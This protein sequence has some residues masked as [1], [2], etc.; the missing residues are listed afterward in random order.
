MK[1]SQIFASQVNKKGAYT[2]I[3]SK[4]LPSTTY[5]NG[6]FLVISTMSIVQAKRIFF[7]IILDISLAK[8][9]LK[10]MKL[11]SIFITG[12]HTVAINGNI[13]GLYF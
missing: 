12:S 6:F 13:N 1:F 8:L 2:K 4:Q 3:V 7:M 11:F 9:V 10:E 5:N